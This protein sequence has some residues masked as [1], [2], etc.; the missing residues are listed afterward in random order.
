[1]V[2]LVAT[3][4]VESLILTSVL[5]S[6]SYLGSQQT[7]SRRSLRATLLARRSVRMDHHAVRWTSTLDAVLAT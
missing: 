2:R 6:L 1:M 4:H 3:L 5:L 7:R